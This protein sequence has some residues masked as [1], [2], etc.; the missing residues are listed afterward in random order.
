MIQILE[1]TDIKLLTRQRA[2]G[3]PNPDFI[4]GWNNSFRI[5]DFGSRLLLDWREG[6][7]MWNSTAWALSFFGRTPLTAETRQETPT[8]IPGV[9]PM[10]NLTISMLC[11]INYWTSSLGGFGAVGEQFVQDGGWIRFV[12]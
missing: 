10:V 2:I 5:K 4:M 12:K 1:N 7:D 3:N 6:G 9:L 8:P 11:V